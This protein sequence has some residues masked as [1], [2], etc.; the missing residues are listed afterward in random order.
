MAKKCIFFAS[1]EYDA[2]VSRYGRRN[3]PDGEI[4]FLAANPNI[5]VK[6]IGS[7]LLQEFERREKGKQIYLYTDDA[8]TYQFYEHRSFDR[9]GEKDVLLHIRNKQVRLKCLLY[10]KVIN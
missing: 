3:H 2:E 9:V 8:C 5:K 1:C 6:G 7:L 4:I 10:G